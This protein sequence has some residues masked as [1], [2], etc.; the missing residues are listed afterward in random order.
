[1]RRHVL[2]P[3][4]LTRTDRAHIHRDARQ[5]GPRRSRSVR[6]GRYG[7]GT[8][9]RPAI[10]PGQESRRRRGRPSIHARRGPAQRARQGRSRRLAT[11]RARGGVA[12][13]ATRPDRREARPGCGARALVRSRSRP[14]GR[15]DA[16]AIS[17]LQPR[18]EPVV[19]TFGLLDM[20]GQQRLPLH[21]PLGGASALVTTYNHVGVRGI[22]WA[23]CD[24]GRGHA[25]PARRR[26]HSPGSSFTVLAG[27]PV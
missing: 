8:H 16:A 14:A 11:G 3:R 21:E 12:P 23:W 20:A 13:Q 2:F 22:F 25:Q 18:G 24:S 26:R 10:A 15:V 6:A 27:G 5:L 19:A 17:L 4:E 7:F 1:M 9:S